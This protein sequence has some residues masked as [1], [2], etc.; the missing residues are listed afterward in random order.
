MNLPGINNH[1]IP[2]C[3]MATGTFAIGIDA[4]IVAG[5]LGNISETFCIS[6]AQAGQLITIFSFSYMFF[7]PLS[8]WVLGNISRKN[9]LQIAMVL[10][11]LGNIIVSQ[12]SDFLQIS[13][14]RILAALGAACYTPQAAAVAS[15]LVEE[16]H[17]GLA[18]SVV[19]G[20]MTLAIALGIPLGTF[21][22][23]LVQWRDIF[24]CIAILGA[25]TFLGLSI[26]LP[27]LN[28]PGKYTLKERL[29]P[30]KNKAVVITLLITFF[31][32]CSEHIV[33]SY[34][35]VLLRNTT[36][37]ATPILP[38]ALLVFGIGAVIGNFIAGALTDS[39]GS[40]FVLR[41]SVLIQTFSLFLLA[42][43][44]DSP[45]WVLPIFLVWGVTGWMYL[46]PIQHHLLSLS[47]FFGALTVSLNSSA[48]YAGIAAGGFFGGI[49]L[50]FL[51]PSSLPLFS[52]PLGAISLILTQVYFKGDEKND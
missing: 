7:A 23:R 11:I 42:F 45:L 26:A 19:Y 12:S 41:V 6:P 31:A 3:L 33:Y 35:S 29:T 20:G 50:Y 21:L 47:K 46:I 22:V 48:L 40:R 16:R 25:F 2:L 34:V 39:F 8:A 10:F 30:L 38:V 15:E 27:A 43:K 32:V 28:A 44:A 13:L 24:I 9:I 51:T 4:F 52:L 14:G 1:L 49:V 36:L 5:I 37:N 17:R 18:I